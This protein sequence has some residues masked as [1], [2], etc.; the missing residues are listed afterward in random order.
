MNSFGSILKKPILKETIQTNH[1]GNQSSTGQK[2]N[3]MLK[4]SKEAQ[5]TLDKYGTFQPNASKPSGN[6]SGPYKFL[7]DSFNV[8]YFLPALTNELTQNG[9]VQDNDTTYFGHINSKGK[10]DGFGILTTSDGHH[11]SGF[12]KDDQ[13]CGEG[14]IIFKNGDF[15]ISK[16]KGNYIDGLGEL[17]FLSKDSIF[18][19]NFRNNMPNGEGELRALHSDAGYSGNLKNGTKH[20]FGTEIW[21]DGTVYE[22]NFYEGEKHGN[23]RFEW[24]D[25]SSYEGQF[26]YNAIEGFGTH[27]WPDGRKYVGGWK[28]NKMQ[29]KLLKST[30]FNQGKECLHGKMARNTKVNTTKTKKRAMGNSFGKTLFFQ[31]FLIFA[32]ANRRNLRWLVEKW[33]TTWIWQIHRY[34]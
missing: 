5:N 20:G 33:K 7:A 17:H 31:Q 28:D 11:F 24:S 8:N 27:T 23:G 29:G 6:M 14:R 15:L 2:W 21:E 1:T 34:R 26:K 30:Y 32:Q 25:G 4:I 22:G 3:N 18:R 9:K 19:G 13:P 16:F 12:F 10:R